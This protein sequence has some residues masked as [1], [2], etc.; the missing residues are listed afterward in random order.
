[1]NKFLSTFLLT[2]VFVVNLT[3]DLNKSPNDKRTYD[4][5]TLKNGIEVVT[6]SDPD[7]ATS[8]ATLSVGVG[9]FKILK[10]LKA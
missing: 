5:F 9:S 7:L 3:A 4:V 1:M 10:T 2:L 8:A 6:V